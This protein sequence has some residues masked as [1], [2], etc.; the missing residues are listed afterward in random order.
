MNIATIIWIGVGVV[1]LILLIWL[2]KG[3]VVIYNKFQY[4][5]AR[6]KRKF[7]DI[8]VIMQQRVDMINALSQVV[9]KYDIHEYKTFKDVIEARSRWTKDTPLNEKVKVAEQIENNFVK[10]QA[11]F[12]RY[13]KIKAD[14]LHKSLMGH[15]NLSRIESRL[16]EARLGYNRVVQQYNERV[17]IFPRNIVAK[18][19]GFKEFE[20]LNFSNQESYNPK[21]IFKD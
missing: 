5:I 9:K 3:Y 2:T 20:Y 15:G 10:L 6:A 17:N 14:E 19:H 16:R 4:W 12:E 13:P 11:V 8:D 21:E 18:I 1:A 7:A